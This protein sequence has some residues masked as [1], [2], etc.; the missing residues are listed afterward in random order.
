MH[1]SHSIRSSIIK[2]QKDKGVSLDVQM[3]TI[4]K[5]CQDKGLKIIKDFSIDESSTKGERKQ[6]HECLTLLKAVLVKVAIVVKL[7]RQASNAIMMTP[8]N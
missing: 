8:M 1:S 3:E 2:K 6:Y 5:Y 7:C 4:T